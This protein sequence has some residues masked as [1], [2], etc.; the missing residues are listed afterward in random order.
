MLISVAGHSWFHGEIPGF[1]IFSWFNKIA[2]ISRILIEL[3]I[4]K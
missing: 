2:L 1:K 3:E 4:K